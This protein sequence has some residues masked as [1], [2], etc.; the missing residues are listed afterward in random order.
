MVIST[1]TSKQRSNKK[2]Q[3]LKI[4]FSKYS[5]FH[6]QPRNSPTTEFNRLCE[7]YRWE[8]RSAERKDAREE[9]NIAIKMEF[10]SLY[11]SD[12]NDINNW[13]KL[14]HVLRIDPVPNT[15][16]KCHEVSALLRALLDFSFSSQ[17]VSRKHVNLVDLVQGSRENIQI[18]KSEKE[19]SD[20]TMMTEKF[21]PKENAVDGGVLRALRRHILDPRECR[22]RETRSRQGQ[23]HSL[24][25]RT[26][27]IR[28]RAFHSRVPIRFLSQPYLTMSSPPRAAKF[29]SPANAPLLG[30]SPLIQCAT[31]PNLVPAAAQRGCPTTIPTTRRS[32]F[33]VTSHMNHHSSFPPLAH[34]HNRLYM[35]YHRLINGIGKTKDILHP[36]GVPCPRRVGLSPF[37]Q[38]NLSLPRASMRV[39]RVISPVG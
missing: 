14:C 3:P 4:F 33:H 15:L 1:Q 8:K 21:F 37:F 34:S 26:T 23:P 24:A 9:F 11:G 20:Y 29:N 39:W 7:E 19:L 31:S 30:F 18:F 5:K 25:N 10:N 27:A 22:P 36:T 6:Y 16:K 35:P 28:S 2:N 32:S 13:Y 12:E 17:A 38:Y